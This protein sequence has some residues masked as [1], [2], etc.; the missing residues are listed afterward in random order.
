MK[1]FVFK[2]LA[3]LETR[4]KD[5]ENSLRLLSMA[6]RAHQHAVDGKMKSIAELQKM[7]ETKR[8]GSKVDIHGLQMEQTYILGTKQKIVQADQGIF[9]ANKAV[10]KAFR[11]Y[12]GTRKKR[13]AMETLQRQSFEEHKRNALKEEQKKLDDLQIMRT[14]LKEDSF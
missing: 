10:Q 7:I 6:R 13:M 9:K 14:R 5:E 1:K 12:L 8:S 3:V 2:F 11:D 4:K